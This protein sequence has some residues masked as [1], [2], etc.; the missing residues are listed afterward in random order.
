MPAPRGRGQETR[1]MEAENVEREAVV[2]SGGWWREMTRYHW[3]VF[4]VATLGWLF[5][6]MDQ[7]L[8]VLARTPALRE[9]LPGASEAEIAQHAGLATAIFI[10][11][12]ATG[13]L[14]FGLFGD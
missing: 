4:S 14:V 8:F 11:G 2:A 9:L 1:T 6:S 12:W 3:W 10:F 5:D 7:R 13:G